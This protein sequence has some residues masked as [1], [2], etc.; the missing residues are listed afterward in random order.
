MV[1]NVDQSLG[2]CSTRSKRSAS[3]TT[4]SSC[5]PPTTAARPR[6]ARRGLAATSAAS[7]TIPG[8]PQRLGGRRRPRPRADRRSAHDGPLPARLGHGLE[9]ALPLLQGPDLRGR[10]PRAVRR[11][12]ARR[13]SEAGRRRGAPSPVPVRHRRAPDAARSRRLRLPGE[14]NGQPTQVASTASASRRCSRRRTRRARTPSSTPSSAGNRGFYRDG[15]KI[16][17][18]HRPGTPFDDG[19]W[20]LYDVRTDPNELHQP[21]PP[22]SRACSRSSPRPGR[23]PPGA[24]TVFPL[25]AAML[26]GRPPA[27]RTRARPARPDR[28]PARPSSS[29]TAPAG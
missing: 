7:C 4:R 3:S 17:T 23:T 2:R 22:T 18:N 5:S 24:N 6:A 11:Q 26:P 29:A 8:I 14:R 10:C 28:C 9:H 20:E 27:R 16:V 25:G 21:A 1:D 15:W 19:E 12:L 13:P